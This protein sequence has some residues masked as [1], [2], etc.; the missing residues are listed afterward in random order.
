MQ[1]LPVVGKRQLRSSYSLYALSFEQV[2][3]LNSANT[4]KISGLNK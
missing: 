1:F 3:Q 4:Q 2:T